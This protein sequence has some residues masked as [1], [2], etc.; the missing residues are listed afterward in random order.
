MA[1]ET[2]TCR[3]SRQR[4]KTDEYSQLRIITPL[5]V[6]LLTFE[7]PVAETELADSVRNV[8]DLRPVSRFKTWQF[9]SRTALPPRPPSF[10]S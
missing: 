2:T 9:T 4:S 1:M 3:V 10:A 7:T 8:D 5:F 6:S